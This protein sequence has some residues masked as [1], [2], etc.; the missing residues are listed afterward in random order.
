MEF[1][2][3][4]IVVVVLWMIIVY[5]S[6]VK[7]NN[8]VKE[9]FSGIDVSLQR[10]YDL[11]QNMVEVTKGY[12]K[13][14]K[15][16]LMAV[17]EKRKLQTAQDAQQYVDEQNQT[18]SRLMVLKEEYPDL[19]ASAVFMKLQDSM[20]ECED[21]L[22]ASRRFYNSNVTEFNTSIKVFPNSIIVSQL[23][24]TEYE[25]FKKEIN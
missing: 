3:I 11:I 19:K 10:R 14:E 25:F 5:N 7:K 8:K 6:L 13:H 21:Q 23:G 17:V 4:G 24:Y 16:T 20:V 12:A 22:S 9:S 2:L 1:I 18:L 15:E